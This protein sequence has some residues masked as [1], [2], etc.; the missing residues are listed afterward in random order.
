MRPL[1]TI[2]DSGWLE[3]RSGKRIL[4]YELSPDGQ[5]LEMHWQ[6]HDSIEDMMKAMRAGTELIEHFRCKAVLSDATRSELDWTELIPWMRY[7]ELPKSIAA[8]MR[9]MA[10]VTSLEPNDAISHHAFHAEFEADARDIPALRYEV[11]NDVDEAR[12]WVRQQ[13]AELDG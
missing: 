12:H 10:S 13:L 7:E 9:I 8:G 5:L 2:T 6:S 11:F 1:L 3:L 4:W